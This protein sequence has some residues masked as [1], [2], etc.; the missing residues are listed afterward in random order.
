MDYKALRESL[1]KIQT[2][3]GLDYFEGFFV[4]WNVPRA[5]LDRIKVDSRANINSGLFISNKAFFMS[6]QVENLYSEF[7]VLQRN[8]LKELSARLVM[9]ENS[10]SI[11]AYDNVTKELQVIEKSNIAEQYEFFFPL[12][13][14]EKNNGT[15][16]DPIAINIA[17]L[18]ASTYNDLILVNGKELEG[19]VQNFTCFLVYLAFV[20]SV[21]KLSDKKNYVSY[22]LKEFQKDITATT[23]MNDIQG[24]ISGA[25]EPKG[26]FDYKINWSDH[27]VSQWDFSAL[28][29]SRKAADCIIDILGYDWCDVQ[30]EVLGA[31]LQEAISP[32][33]QPS[34]YTTNDNIHKVIGPLFID[35]LHQI[36]E[37]SK[38]NFEELQQLSKRIEGMHLLDPAC[39]A[40]N[41]LIFAYKELLRLGHLIE[42]ETRGRIRCKFPYKNLHGIDDS[43]IA[44]NIAKLSLYIAISQN[45][46]VFLSL[47]EYENSIEIQTANPLRIEWDNTV[48]PESELFIFGNPP[49]KGAKKMTDAQVADTVLVLGDNKGVK[50]L[51]YAAC[52]FVK[53]ARLF[54]YRKGAFSFVTTNSLIQGQQVALLWPLVFEQGCYIQFAYQAFKWKNDA[55]N[56]TAVTVVIIGV[57]PN[58]KDCPR[59]LFGEDKRLIVSSI[60][61]Y[62]TQGEAIVEKRSKPLSLLPYME[63]GN[64]PYDQG[65][66]LLTPYEHNQIIKDYPHSARL[67]RRVVGSDEF[68]NGIERWCLWIHN[69]DLDEAMSFPPIAERIEKCKLFRQQLKDVNGKK[70]AL[71]SHQ[72]REAR[73]T[74]KYSLVVPAVSSERREYIPIGFIDKSTI[75]T[76][77][78]FVIYD[79]EP[80]IFAVVSSKMHNLWI[81]TVCGGLET[82]LRY[83]SR[84]GYNTFPFPNIS[85]E[86]KE[87]LK[88]CVY[89]ILA[90]RELDSGKTLADLYDPEKMSVGLKYAHHLLDAAVERCY[91]ELPFVSDQDRL[92]FL[93]ELYKQ[94]TEA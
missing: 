79:C 12:I 94:M 14:K 35:E 44:V 9:I 40:G 67:F 25:V 61:P 69:E 77:L 39:G 85:N 22:L 75:V 83:S 88:K 37:R 29:I 53:A 92:D 78:S 82:R 68:I 70:L 63:K 20:D 30:P 26:S 36:Y 34:C 41:F 58:S 46:E 16:Y 17:E 51:D 64:M 76:N 73:E 3:Q 43:D 42:K 89:A 33:G 10:H 71:R 11:L 65:N 5:T 62:L 48:P 31:L 24:L 66:L 18:F 59:E 52:W 21:G 74:S 6:T 19:Q 91:R 54:R 50:E 8:G 47:S 1:S 93:F 55:K 38:G 86:K 90:E 80:W 56:N 45:A 60:S 84:L 23:I 49:Y 27:S 57:R 13:G 15:S 2:L 28:S 81:R 7:S 32:P 4:A 87:V 72:F